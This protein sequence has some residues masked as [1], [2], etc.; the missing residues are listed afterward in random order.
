MAVNLANLREVPVLTY[1]LPL[2]VKGRETLK[3][4]ILLIMIMLF[5]VYV[6]FG[7]IIP[8]LPVFVQEEG[9]DPAGLGLLLSIY[10]IVSFLVAPFWG[11]LSDRKG[12]RPILLTATFGFAL[13]FV[14]LALSERHI[15]LLYLSRVLGGLFSGALSGVAMAYVADITSHEERT[16]SMGFV[17]MSIGLGFIFG[18]ALGGL[19]SSWSLTLPF[20]VSAGACTAV[21]AGTLLVLPES[22][23]K[24]VQPAE[25]SHSSR[26]KAFSGLLRYLYILTFVVSVSL[27]GLESTFQY[28]EMEVFQVTSSQIGLM[29]MFSGFADALVQGG[30]IRPIAKR[31]W[32]KQAIG[33]GLFFSVMG[34][35]MILQCAGFWTATVA[36]TIFS[37]GNAM[38]RPCVSSLL[39]QRTTGGQGITTGLNSSMDSLGRIAGPLLGT[40][41]FGWKSG[42]PYLA[43]ILLSLA[44][45]YWLWKFHEL[46]QKK[47]NAGGV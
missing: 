2:P 5:F 39:T 33:T 45:G 12:R 21:F 44:A 34:F 23:D 37:M 9:V 29:F 6:G 32:E 24:S 28:F 25:H 38:V 27:A 42:A 13:S 26:W 1:G 40:S 8:V 14:L 15:W 16:K 43:G 20:W 46:D 4:P 18:P 3:K 19:L 47:K 36:L 11:A 17:G 31:K 22:L 35:I 7:I 30:L 41:L 10:S